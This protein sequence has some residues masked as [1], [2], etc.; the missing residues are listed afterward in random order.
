MLIKLNNG[1]LLE[2][3]QAACERDRKR[4]GDGAIEHILGLMK[5][6]AVVSAAVVVHDQIVTS[7][8]ADKVSVKPTLLAEHS[9]SEPQVQK[10]WI[11]ALQLESDAWRIWPN[12]DSL[13]NDLFDHFLDG[14]LTFDL[15]DRIALSPLGNLLDYPRRMEVWRTL[16]DRCRH[17]F[18]TSTAEAWV[19][20]LPE[21]STL[22]D[23][24]R[25]EQ[26]LAI[27]IA[28]PEVRRELKTALKRLSFE[29][30]VNVFTGNTHLSHQ[31]FFEIFVSFY[32]SSRPPSPA[33]LERAARL[34]ASRNWHELT[35]SVLRRYGVTD[36]LRGFFHICAD[37]LYLWD[38]VLHGISRPSANELYDL[39][40]ET[41]RELY[42]TGPMHGEIWTRA[43]G[44]LSQLDAA[45]TGRQQWEA[46]IRKIRYGNRVRAA[47]LIEAMR[48]DYPLNNR[49]GYL[50]REWQ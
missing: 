2:A 12:A 43:G 33:E 48:S 42:P 4:F 31:L 47:S 49:L 38:R 39:L 11:E 45:G 7:A 36:H 18:L 29:D 3:L 34:A 44:D 8:A 20:S 9:L 26:E 40:V 22:R 16:P 23:F 50:A 6:T 41:A 24:F 27:A 15:I 35:R 17:D 10:I 14:E 13:R 32:G 1:D 21:S 28:S 19:R 46:A 30:V 5:P 25:P 37:H